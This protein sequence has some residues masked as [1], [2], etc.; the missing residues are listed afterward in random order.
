MLKSSELAANGESLPSSPIPFPPV[1][2]PADNNE[3][4]SALRDALEP[5]PPPAFLVVALMFS[6]FDLLIDPKKF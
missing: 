6:I 2:L 5:P 4:N 1:E 3:D